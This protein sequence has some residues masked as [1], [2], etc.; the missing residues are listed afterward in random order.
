MP[1]ESIPVDAQLVTALYKPSQWAVT[2]DLSEHDRRS[3]YLIA[4]R[5]LRLPFMEVFDQPVAQGSC[6]GGRASR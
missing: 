6:A 5:N 3:I 2:K 1:R 4:Q